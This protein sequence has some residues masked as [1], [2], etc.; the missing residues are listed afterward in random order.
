MSAVPR[1]SV[2]MSVF[3]NERFVAAAIESICTQTFADFE[4]LIV[5]DGSRDG[6]GAIIAEHARRD[7]RIRILRQ[8]NRGLIESLNRLIAEA[9]APLIARMDGDDI[10][11][12]ERFARQLAFLGAH[13]DYGVV[14]TNT[15]DMDENGR[16]RECTDFHPLD[17]AALAAALDHASPLCHS[18]VMMRRE[19]VRRV[20]GYRPAFR[21][22][23]DYDLWLRLSEITRLG[24]LPDRLLLYRRSPSQISSRHVVSQQTGA[25]VARLA[26]RE[27]LA[28]RPDPTEGLAALPP[29]EA[30]DGLFG[31]PGIAREVRTTVALNLVYSAGAMA[32]DGFELLLQHV[33]AGG[34]RPG[35]WR[36]VGR[37]LL[38]RKPRHA[39]RLAATL[40]RTRRA[41]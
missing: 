17:H 24:N 20:G 2:A 11:R 19:A 8:E 22:C 38:F 6:S 9:R 33:R 29:I 5:D 13:P 14:G 3:D 10:A 27:R 35:L 12:P 4:F 1:I 7:P 37:L 39:A 36:T 18:S 28:G 31:R 40:L 32:G 23:E 16:I 30:L 15:H 26:R 34:A 41:A 21:H 25:V